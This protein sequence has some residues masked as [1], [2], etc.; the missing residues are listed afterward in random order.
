MMRDVYAGANETIIFLGD[1][2]G[3]RI[4]VQ[5]LE[6]RPDRQAKFTGRTLDFKIIEPFLDDLR[7]LNR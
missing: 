5:S 7:V 3:H 1:G 4:T 6:S 2:H